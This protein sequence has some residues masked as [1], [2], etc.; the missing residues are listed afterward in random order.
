MF[1]K[2]LRLLGYIALFPAHAV[3]FQN[4][5][6]YGM[7]GSISKD[8]FKVGGDLRSIL[9]RINRDRENEQ[10]KNLQPRA[11]DV[12]RHRQSQPSERCARWIHET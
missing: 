2:L 9:T 12:R 1:N 7:K 6:P 4:D 3:M 10:T 11:H 8:W 5:K